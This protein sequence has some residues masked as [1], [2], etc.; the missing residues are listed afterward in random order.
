MLVVI[1]KGVE[2]LAVSTKRDYEQAGIAELWWQEQA[3]E[4]PANLV[5]AYQQA[6]A[7]VLDLGHALEQVQA[8]A[9]Q[10]QA[11]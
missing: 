3:V 1:A 4:A 7:Q 2:V 8:R 5:A 10:G 11:E 9:G 6:L